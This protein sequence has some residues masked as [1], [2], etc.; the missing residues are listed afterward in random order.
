VSYL[1]GIRER[2]LSAFNSNNVTCEV[3]KDHVLVDDSLSEEKVRRII[4]TTGFYPLILEK[5]MALIF[6]YSN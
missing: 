6:P 1:S 5:K 3:Q 2:F 4:E